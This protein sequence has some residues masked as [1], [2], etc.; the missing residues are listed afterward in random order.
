MTDILTDTGH[1]HDGNPPDTWR[2]R[3]LAGPVAGSADWTGPNTARR[4][5]RGA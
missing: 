1:C 3:M 2:R 5:A 4:L